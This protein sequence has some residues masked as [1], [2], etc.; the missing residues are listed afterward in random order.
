[1]NK[2]NQHQLK[3]L[4]N[5]NANFMCQQVDNFI[6]YE[7]R[8]SGNPSKDLLAY[9]LQN[10]QSYK[11][12]LQS[13]LLDLTQEVDE[14]KESLTKIVNEIHKKE[15]IIKTTIERNKQVVSTSSNVINLL[16]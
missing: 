14:K 3:N 9:D 7:R 2:A 16:R 11:E 5:S 6:G 1:M 10:L 13:Y 12:E 4:G 8:P 15:H